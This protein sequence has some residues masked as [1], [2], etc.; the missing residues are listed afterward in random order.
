MLA[1]LGEEGKEL[2]RR[3]RGPEEHNQHGNNF[4]RVYEAPPRF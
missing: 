1:F 4:P 3:L 2:N